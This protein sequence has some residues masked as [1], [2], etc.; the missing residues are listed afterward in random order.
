MVYKGM[1]ITT[2]KN[3]LNLLTEYAPFLKSWSAFQQP[4][5]QKMNGDMFSILMRSWDVSSSAH[6]AEHIATYQ[7]DVV[8]TFDPETD[9]AINE[10][11][12]KNIS[13]MIRDG[14]ENAVKNLKESKII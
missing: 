13:N 11:N 5:I 6:S 2:K 8:F 9:L 10:I 1:K 12:K 7:P 14:Y 3:P 4:E